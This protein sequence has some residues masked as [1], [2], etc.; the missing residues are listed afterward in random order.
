MFATTVAVALFHPSHA[1]QVQTTRTIPTVNSLAQ[2]AVVE[3]FTSEG[4][5][6]CP[7]A[8]RLAGQLA[9]RAEE[10]RQPIYILSF[11]VDYWDYLGWKDP[12]SD[13]AYSRRQKQYAR[14]I[15]SRQIYTPQAIVNGT[16]AFVGSDAQRLKATINH[17]LKQKADASLTVTIE[18]VAKEPVTQ[19][20]RRS[21]DRISVTYEVIGQSQDAVLNLAVV[22]RGLTKKVTRGENQ[23]RTLSHHNVVRLLSTVDLDTNGRGHQRIDLPTGVKRANASI[24]AY[25]QDSTTMA[26]QAAT[27][28][29]L[30]PVTRVRR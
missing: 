27:R 12:F 2:F 21:E 18:P 8:D 23:G 3:L 24:I 13:A 17:A 11:H 26:I 10:K 16:T 7:P 5:S 4:C 28:V 25:V 14:A 20:K 22:E 9:Q 19:N 29:N 1:G 30:T 6:S 15:Q